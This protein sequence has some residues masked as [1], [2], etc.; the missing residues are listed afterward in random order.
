ML[1]ASH[2]L[3]TS[4]KKRLN[5]LVRFSAFFGS[6]MTVRQYSLNVDVL[7]SVSWQVQARIWD[8]ILER[9]TIYYMEI[10]VCKMNMRL[11]RKD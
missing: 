7:E 3:K 8:I 10:D 2:G 9:V 1:F 11:F 4:K 6:W 5:K